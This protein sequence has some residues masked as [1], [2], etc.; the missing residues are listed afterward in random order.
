MI[1]LNAKYVDLTAEVGKDPR[2]IYEEI[3]KDYQK[4]VEDYRKKF[5][6]WITIKDRKQP[7]VNP[8][9]L[10][11]QVPNA[12]IPLRISITGK[13]GKEEWIYTEIAPEVKDG[14][15][16]LESSQKIVQYGELL[17]D[18]DES[19]D[20]AYFLLEKHPMFKK[21]H[22]YVYDE[23][24]IERRKAEERTNATKLDELIYGSNS[25]L[26]NDVN[27]LRMV[28]KRWGIPNAD[29]M[30]KSALQN[31]LHDLV[32][33]SDKK[34]NGRGIVEFIEDVKGG[35]TDEM[36][37]AS[38]VRD[39]IDKNIL[40]F[41]INNKTWQIDYG[42]T[43]KDILMVSIEDL[44]RKDEALILYMQS[45]NAMYSRLVATMGDAKPV[46][47]IQDVQDCDDYSKVSD[48]AKAL[49]VTNFPKK[50]IDELKG[51]IVAKLKE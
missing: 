1:Y 21:G 22:Y 37:V 49:G 23:D 44:Q 27:T 40:V 3:A 35:D 25:R 47:N 4:K 34:K 13:G 20:L 6:K 2:N 16:K 32:T 51:L 36:K 24:E 30:T 11:E 8:T 41:N 46:I 12:T 29:R 10:L 17:I 7:K 42:D 38:T 50:K 14:V 15:A 31:R 48:W 5:G 43:L 19:P 26:V 28:A 33:E 45:D 39:A 18:L 9:G